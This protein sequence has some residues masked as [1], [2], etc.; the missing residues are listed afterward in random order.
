MCLTVRLVSASLNGCTTMVDVEFW[1]L[2][3]T[4]S[5]YVRARRKEE[6]ALAHIKLK[7]RT[8]S[9][10]RNG[11][12]LCSIHYTQLFLQIVIVSS[13]VTNQSNTSRR[14]V[15][16][17]AI[18]CLIK[19]LKINKSYFSFIFYSITLYELSFLTQ[20]TILLASSDIIIKAHTVVMNRCV[21]SRQLCRTTIIDPD[22]FQ[23]WF[24]FFGSCL[25]K[26]IG[27]FLLASYEWDDCI[28]LAL[29]LCPT[30]FV[31]SRCHIE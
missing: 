6:Q 7:V 20:S 4:S 11:L 19:I 12:P 27:I 29:W 1:T 16:P 14:S 9:I 21:K 18:T 17:K 3:G 30:S 15:C 31:L 25:C 24:A 26:L 28:C 13:K 5:L 8:V 10:E 2:A 22:F 23:N